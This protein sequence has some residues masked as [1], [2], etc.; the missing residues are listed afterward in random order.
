MVD[1]DIPRIFRFFFFINKV[2]YQNMFYG[3]TLT[4]LYKHNIRI[5]WRIHFTNHSINIF[6]ISI[7]EFNS[8]FTRF[9]WW[10][11]L[12]LHLKDYGSRATKKIITKWST[13]LWNLYSIP[14]IVS[15]TFHIITSFFKQIVLK[16]LLREPFALKCPYFC[17]CCFSPPDWS[18]HTIINNYV[19]NFPTV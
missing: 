2:N 13:V 19:A 1:L 14:T 3:K 9:L 16:A 7:N 6:V 8:N 12:Q 15:Y 5:N 11:Y 18:M 10:N 4:C 17:I